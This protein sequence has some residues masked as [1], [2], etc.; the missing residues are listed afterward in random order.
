MSLEMMVIVNDNMCK[1]FT[2]RGPYK[3]NA[4]FINQLRK[5]VHFFQSSV[6]Q[7]NGYAKIDH[8]VYHQRAQL[9]VSHNPTAL[10]NFDSFEVISE[11]DDLDPQL[12]E[13]EYPYKLFLF[14]DKL[15][16]KSCKILELVIVLFLVFQTIASMFITIIM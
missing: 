3:Q 8:P 13:D 4:E 10:P 5:K 6:S 15:F 2:D 9:Q 7:S 1:A 14:K 11:L 12:F 16:H